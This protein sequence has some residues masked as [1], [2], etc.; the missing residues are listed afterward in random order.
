M[1]QLNVFYSSSFEWLFSVGKPQKED[2]KPLLSRSL[3]TN[4]V[5][6]DTQL[7]IKWLLRPKIANSTCGF[8][9]SI[10]WTVTFVRCNASARSASIWLLS[11]AMKIDR[12]VFK[13]FITRFSWRMTVSLVGRHIS[14]VT[15]PFSL[16]YP[17]HWGA[18]NKLGLCGTCSHART[19]SIP[20]LRC[21]PM[22]APLGSLV[23]INSLAFVNISSF[24]WRYLWRFRFSNCT[25]KL[26]G[27]PGK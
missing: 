15:L 16:R 17:K 19:Q 12:I 2:G 7:P 6:D 23:L 18:A 21:I 10:L 13:C 24:Q 8:G 27:A 22:N 3:F 26:A 14:C 1:L 25:G 4:A 9:V 11:E 5:K 20:F